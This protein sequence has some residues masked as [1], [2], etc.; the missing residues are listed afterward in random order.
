MMSYSQIEQ[1]LLEHGYSMPEGVVQ[2]SGF[3]RFNA[4]GKPKSN[5]SA[6]L[7]W[8]D[9]GVCQFGNW[10][11]GEVITVTP[12]GGL[13]ASQSAEMKRQIEAEK[14]KRDIELDKQ[15]KQASALCNQLFEATQPADDNHPYLARKGISSDGL[16][17]DKAMNLIIPVVGTG[18]PFKDVIQT[19]QTIGKDGFKKFHS[20]GRLKGGYYPVQWVQDAPIVICEGLATGATLKQVYTP[21]FSVIC[22]FNSGNLLPVARVMREA[23]PEQRIIIGADN[24]HQNSI[25]TGLNKAM[26]VASLIGGEVSYPRFTSD[27]QGSDWNDRALLDGLLGGVL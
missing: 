3:I 16:R 9:I 26:Q 1:S 25:N 17:T 22:A 23:Y 12:D 27:E 7:N 2:G 21:Y 19:L 10:G 20:G 8:F 15:Y 14:Q 24:D 5:K 4:P 11:S 6:W 13:T 18:E